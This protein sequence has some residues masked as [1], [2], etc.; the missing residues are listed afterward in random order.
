MKH[1]KR[2]VRTTPREIHVRLATPRVAPEVPDVWVVKGR[3]IR[4]L[5]PS[6]PDVDSQPRPRRRGLLR[7]LALR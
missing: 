4:F 7:A 3:V 5:D 6:R 2:R 1:S